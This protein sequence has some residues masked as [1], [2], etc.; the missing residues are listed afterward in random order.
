MLS[1]YLVIVALA[2]T[3]LAASG[4]GS[5]K[6]VGSVA[7]PK[8]LSVTTT[9]TTVKTPPPTTTTVKLASGKPLTRTTLIGKGDAICART[10]SKLSAISVV[11]RS[12]FSRVIP[13]VSIY[14]NVEFNELSK[15]VPPASLAHDWKKIINIVHLYG[16]YVSQI[17]S[18]AKSNNYSSAGPLVRLAGIIHKE[19]TVLAKHDGFKQCS[20]IG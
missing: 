4:C 12:D 18:Y 13:Q 16:V 17:P 15:L 5:S 9:P 19:L 10:N 7:A 8:N 14:D 11:N 20:Q 2:T 6:T 3:A 1:I